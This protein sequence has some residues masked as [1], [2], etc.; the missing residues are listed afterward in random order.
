MKVLDFG[1]AKVMDVAGG[2]GS[3]TR[4]G[5][6]LGTPGYMSPEQVKNA[7]AVDPRSDLWAAGVV[8]YEMLS[9]KHPYGVRPAGAD[10]GGAARS[11]DPHLHGSAPAGL[12]GAVL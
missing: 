11:A 12:L 6:V 7:K 3:K 5:A 9:C 1:I 10:G 4:T 2:I 8:F